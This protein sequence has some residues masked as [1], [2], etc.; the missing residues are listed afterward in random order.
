[1]IFSL[2][3]EYSYSV[4]LPFDFEIT[5]VDINLWQISFGAGPVI[6]SE[7]GGK[8]QN[9]LA[10]IA[11]FS[12]GY[13]S[14]GDRH[15]EP[16]PPEQV[17]SKR[18]IT[19]YFGMYQTGVCPFIR[20]QDKISVSAGK[21]SFGLLGSINFFFK[22]Q[23]RGEFIFLKNLPNESSGTYRSSLINYSLCG[24]MGYSIYRKNKAI[25]I[26]DFN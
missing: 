5:T 23:V 8:F 11:S 3:N 22:P 17:G 18:D 10:T 9:S 2:K 26:G 15:S 20:I 13:G 12:I 16:P 7:I 14:V 6:K 24:V 21:F 19:L 4:Y 25:A 1:M